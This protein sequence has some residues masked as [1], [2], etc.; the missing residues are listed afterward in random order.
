MA[1]RSVDILIRARDEASRKFGRIGRSTQ[2]LRGNFMSL[3]RSL[4][5]A[6]GLTFGLYTLVRGLKAVITEA[7]QFEKQIASVS[8]MLS[9]A[10]MKY[11]PA[12]REQIARLATEFGQTTETLTRGLYDILSAQIS[13]AEA[14]EVLLVATKAAIGGMTDTATST[15][16]LI[17]VLRA[18]DFE[19]SRAA[20]VSDVLFKIVEKGVIRYEE[21]AE[22]IGTVAPSARA[23]GLTLEELAAAIATVVAVE[24][25]ARAMTALRQAIFE[26]AEAGVDLMTF[27]RSFEGADLTEIIEAGI[28]KRAALGMVILSGNIKLLDENLAAVAD[29]AG[30]S[31]AA[32]QKMADTTAF[33]MDRLRG[34]W[35]KLMR[36][37]G[38]STV[39]QET[40]RLFMQMAAD[41]NELREGETDL[42]RARNAAWEEGKSRIRLHV[43]ALGELKAVHAAMTHP[44]YQQIDLADRLAAAQKRVA[45][46]ARMISPIAA[47]VEK[48]V[49]GQFDSIAAAAQKAAEAI[50]QAFLDPLKKAAKAAEDLEVKRIGGF[51]DALGKLI[52]EQIEATRAFDVATGVYSEVDARLNAIAETADFT[53]DEL[54]IL[55]EKLQEIFDLT[56]VGEDVALPWVVWGEESMKFRDELNKGVEASRAAWLA[57]VNK[58]LGGVAPQLG[59]RAAAME[60][61]FLRRAPGTDPIL[62]ETKKATTQRE[63]QATL[64]E[65]IAEAAEAPI[66]LPWA[67]AD[68]T[69][70]GGL[71][72]KN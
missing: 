30:A 46:T 35:S 60:E 56:A 42:Q 12:Y 14:T 69:G 11:L 53:A 19:A 36:D 2:N 37:I 61:R 34:E 15:K 17:R 40:M 13:A 50:D 45:E 22:H 57:E 26:A 67:P 49:V 38:Q 63:K 66:Q 68:L 7:I 59:G 51:T 9:E 52:Q 24:E 4:V 43:A 1:V 44:A 6:F 23:A 70:A 71:P 32:F 18:Y 54:E 62:V 64:L 20:D 5:G 29:R 33:E 41:I 48:A 10:S 21:L 58:G 16:A 31:E 3:G 39:I 65:R 72:W 27:I 8:T 28:P 47:T 55:R 25:P